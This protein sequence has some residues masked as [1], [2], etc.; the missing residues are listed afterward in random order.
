MDHMSIRSPL[1]AHE[2]GSLSRSPFVITVTGKVPPSLRSLTPL[3]RANSLGSPFTVGVTFYLPRFQ[4]YKR[5]GASTA[6]AA[7]TARVPI[8]HDQSGLLLPH[9]PRAF[10]F[11]TLP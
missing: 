10:R 1:F 11:S 4:R 8:Y 5:L 3:W 2:V 7:V 6:V 9:V